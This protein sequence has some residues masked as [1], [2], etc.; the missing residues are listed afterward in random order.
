MFALAAFGLGLEVERTQSSTGLVPWLSLRPVGELMEAEL[1][2][3]VMPKLHIQV[4]LLLCD[5][6]CTIPVFVH[7]LPMENILKI[8]KI[9]TKTHCG[10]TQVQK[11]P[12]E[13]WKE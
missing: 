4:T 8:L 7:K 2:R 3:S 6:A 12:H 11:Y 9:K 5:G 10:K 13:I 1:G